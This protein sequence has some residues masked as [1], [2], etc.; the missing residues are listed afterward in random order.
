MEYAATASSAAFARHSAACGADGIIAAASDRSPAFQAHSSALVSPGV[1]DRAVGQAPS[2]AP[3]A[4]SGGRPRRPS[5]PRRRSGSRGEPVPDQPGRGTGEHRP[6]GGLPAQTPAARRERLVLARDRAHQ[7]VDVR[8]WPVAAP[9][10]RGPGRRRRSAGRSPPSGPTSR[11]AGWR[12]RRCG[13]R[14]G[15]GR[16]ACAWRATGVVLVA[17]EVALGGLQRSRGHLRRWRP[18]WTGVAVEERARDDPG[19]AARQRRSPRRDRPRT[20]RSAGPAR[21]RGTSAGLS[22]PGSRLDEVGTGPSCCR[23]HV[24]PRGR[25]RGRRCRRRPSRPPREHRR[26]GRRSRR[27]SRLRASTE[28]ARSQW[29]PCTVPGPETPS[30]SQSPA[31]GTPL[32]VPNV[33]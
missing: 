13:R 10:R 29:R 33:N 12:A 1:S 3:P 32:G 9:A 23:Y 20:G 24:L 31:T 11:A 26:A 15:S 14:A 25:R 27:S 8:P 30:P 22:A 17:E 21:G 4:G 7:L 6:V 18:A 5:S 19:S 16:S 2:R 28:R